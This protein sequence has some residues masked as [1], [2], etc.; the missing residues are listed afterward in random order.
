MV[1]DPNFWR[2]KNLGIYIY[3]YIHVYFIHAVALIIL[4]CCV[5]LDLVLQLESFEIQFCFG[6]KQVF[7]LEKDLQNLKSILGLKLA[8]GH[9]V[10]FPRNFPR[11]GLA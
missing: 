4:C 11:R 6:F 8:L 7:K 10:L 2:N 3:I 9:F 1:V 5:L